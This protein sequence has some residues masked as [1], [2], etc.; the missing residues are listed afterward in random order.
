MPNSVGLAIDREGKI[1]LCIFW[2]SAVSFVK[3]VRLPAWIKRI[4]IDE[5]LVPCCFK[6]YY[7]M[8]RRADI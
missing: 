6:L 1:T 3:I 8:E 5:L 4:E 7:S 2:T